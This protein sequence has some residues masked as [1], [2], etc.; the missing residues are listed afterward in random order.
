M[1]ASIRC[2]AEFAYGGGGFAKGGTVKLYYDGGKVGE[3]RVNVKSNDPLRDARARRRQ[4]GRYA[5]G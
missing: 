1:G 4:G 3:G 5:T 2:V